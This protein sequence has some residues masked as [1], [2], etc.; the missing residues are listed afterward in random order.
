MMGIGLLGSVAT[1]GPLLA[2]PHAETSV[3]Y[4]VEVIRCGA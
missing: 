3:G 4:F 2:H 1:A